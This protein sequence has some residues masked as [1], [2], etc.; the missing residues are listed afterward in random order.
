M[1]MRLHKE[2]VDTM[3]NKD[4]TLF[5][6]GNGLD[7]SFKLPT[8]YR[9]FMID[10]KTKK[11]LQY[12]KLGK[13]M[14]HILNNQNWVDIEIELYNYCQQM[15]N[16]KNT[17]GDNLYEDFK[18]DYLTLR[19]CLK[20]YLKRIMNIEFSADNYAVKLIKDLCDSQDE[21]LDVITF[22]YTDTLERLTDSPYSTTKMKVHHVH[23]SLDSD[24][25]FGVE[26][27]ADL[28]APQ[29]YLYKSYS[30]YKDLRPF[31]ELLPYYT[32][33]VFYGYSLGDTDKQ[34]FENYFRNLTKPTENI[35]NI[36]I[37]HYGTNAFDTVNWQLMRYTGHNLTG[38]EMYNKVEFHDCQNKYESPDFI[39]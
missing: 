28:Y 17:H 9:E 34:Y 3:K 25:V 27:S 37:Y 22:N 6:V 30:Q 11:V 29:V 23:G 1:F 36:A 13:Y 5:I 4:N 8:S 7:L 16:A 18:Q 10:D 33:I 32:N 31:R 15:Y 14:Y 35:R 24:I 21:P 39:K 12:T 26:D 20:K 38:L 2:K 19:D